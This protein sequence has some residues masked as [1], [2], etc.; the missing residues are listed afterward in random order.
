MLRAALHARNIFYSM[1]HVKCVCKQSKHFTQ[2]LHNCAD[3]ASFNCA[4]VLIDCFLL[5]INRH[6]ISTSKS[7]IH[8]APKQK[9]KRTRW[10]GYPRGVVLHFGEFGAALTLTVGRRCRNAL[11][12]FVG[13]ASR[14]RVPYFFLGRSHSPAPLL[15]LCPR[16]PAH[17]NTSKIEEDRGRAGSAF[18]PSNGC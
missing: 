6:R 8:R 10:N 12:P 15:L 4:F 7:S 13:A 9:P 17:T 3:N 2:M 16:L 5:V 18:E 11:S 1:L 14:C